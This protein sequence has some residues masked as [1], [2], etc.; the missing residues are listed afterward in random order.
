MYYYFFAVRKVPGGGEIRAR[1]FHSQKK[2]EPPHN[3][4]VCDDCWIMWMVY[5]CCCWSPGN[6][7][8]QLQLP[9]GCAVCKWHI[10]LCTCS[11]LENHSFPLLTIKCNCTIADGSAFF[12]NL[13]AYIFTSW[14]RWE[15]QCN[16]FIVLWKSNSSIVVV[17]EWNNLFTKTAYAVFIHFCY[18]QCWRYSIQLTN[19]YFWKMSYWWM[20]SYKWSSVDFQSDWVLVVLN[21]AERLW[22]LWDICVHIC[23][24]TCTSRSLI[25]FCWSHI[26]HHVPALFFRMCS[27]T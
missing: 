1:C 18:Y 26:S 17:V 3:L 20:I 7:S 2:N 14:T 5:H 16:I 9:R 11:V 4:E 21:M 15:N 22:L 25:S 24:S 13:I 19:R 23:T 27:G 6:W 8:C 10:W 12:D